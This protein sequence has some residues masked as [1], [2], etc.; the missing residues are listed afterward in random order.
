MSFH[1]PDFIWDSLVQD[2]ATTYTATNLADCENRLILGGLGLITIY[3]NEKPDYWEG[4][5]VKIVMKSGQ[6]F[7]CQTETGVGLTLEHNQ[8]KT[9]ECIFQ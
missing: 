4:D 5:Y 9:L 3:H 1:P 6:I 7:N 2:K 8:S